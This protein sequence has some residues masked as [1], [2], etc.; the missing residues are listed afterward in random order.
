MS[1]SQIDNGFTL[2]TIFAA[3]DSG[4]S[5]PMCIT[6]VGAVKEDGQYKLCNMLPIKTRSWRKEKLGSIRFIF[7]NTHQFDGN[8]GLQMNSFVDSLTTLWNL[9]PVDVDYY[10]ADNLDVIYKAL[11]FDYHIGEGNILRASGSSD[12]R[13]RIVYGA[14]QG[15]YYPHEF[16]HIYLSPL[17]TNAHGYFSEGYAT[18]LGGSKGHTLSWHIK[19]MDQYLQEHTDLNLDTVLTFWH[20]DYYTDPIYVFGGLLCKMAEEKDGLMMLKKLMSYGKS[21]EDFYK[22]VEAVFGVPQNKL[23]NFLRAKIAEYAAK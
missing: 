20:M 9:K 10:M 21:D 11:G 5:Y 4:F 19:R 16:V 15:E 23:N 17:F 7:P 1:V 18:L 3:T 6:E 13:N 12:A 22:A 8:L 2:R 14:G